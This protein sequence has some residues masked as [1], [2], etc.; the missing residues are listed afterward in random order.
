MVVLGW[1][2]RRLVVR[3]IVS[4]RLRIFLFCHL[5]GTRLILQVLQVQLRKRQYLLLIHL[6]YAWSYV[7][8]II[9]GDQSEFGKFCLQIWFEVSV[10]RLVLENGL[11]RAVVVSF[12]LLFAV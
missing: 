7:F 12:W 5:I 8:I 1:P 4:K 2:Q 10:F 11:E 9:S 6:F 3:R